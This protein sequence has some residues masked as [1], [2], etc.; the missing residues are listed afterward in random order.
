MTDTFTYHA[1]LSYSHK[2]KKTVAIIQRSI[3]RLGLPFY[4]RWRPNV[5]LF[6]DERKIPLSGSLP[7]EILKGLQASK[8]LIVIASRNSAAS[9]W[10]KEEIRRWH[11]L[12]Q[13]KEGFILRFNFIL[14][15]DVAEWDYGKIFKEPPVW[16]NLQDY[17]RDGKVR[18]NNANY[19][20]EIAKIKGL[21]LDKKPDEI[22]DD[23]SRDKNVFRSML[24]GVIILLASLTIY[25]VFERNQAVRQRDIVLSRELLLNAEKT[26]ETDPA[27]S[28]SL[29]IYAVE[30]QSKDE[31][32]LSSET[33]SS[34]L[35]IIKANNKMVPFKGRGNSISNGIEV[36]A[37]SPDHSELAIG[38]QGDSIEVMD[39]KDFTVRYTLPQKWPVA[40]GW[41]S[42][43]KYLASSGMDDHAV[44]I[45]DA[46]KGVLLKRRA[47]PNSGGIPSVDW[48]LHTHELAFAVAMG[49][50][51]Q[52]H[53]MD[54]DRDTILFQLPGT[55]A[56]WSR[57]G[58]KLAT[59]GSGN[60]AWSIGLYDSAGHLLGM[61]PGHHRYVGSISWSPG[62]AYVAT[63]SVDDRVIIW[64]ASTCAAV[65]TIHQ[66]FPL[67]TAWSPSGR[68]LVVGGGEEVVKIYDAKAKYS[69]VDSIDHTTTIAGDEITRSAIQGY[70]LHLD[71]PPDGSYLLL[72][73]RA[74]SIIYYDARLIHPG[75]DRE[76]LDIAR[77]LQTRQLSEK[78]ILEYL[79]LQ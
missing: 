64:D 72:A 45:W 35:R 44:C 70:V 5:S 7:E 56:A 68:Y 23:A 27:L 66:T 39:S 11:E 9:T 18:T 60:E 59:G 52:V 22:I 12:N 14:I 61:R 33:R 32:S 29:A 69:L 20:W 1:F 79:H 58:A 77:S 26:I 24:I 28:L 36:F 16:A 47:Y 63:S 31:D 13:D 40:I 17:C 55:I 54:V 57:D 3:E 10:V 48:R 73:D 62:N 43:G 74:G 2:D 19:E 78:E 42:D 25:S 37:F 75:T 41:S 46:Q 15:D 53:V 21:L 38:S 67:S 71:W 34:L 76:L 8:Y 6:R 50:S 65:D 49:D 51:S 30:K 4:K